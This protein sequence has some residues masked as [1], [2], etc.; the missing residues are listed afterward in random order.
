M[1][2]LIIIT[3]S[4]GT[5]STTQGGQ[6]TGMTNISA[7]SLFQVVGLVPLEDCNAEDCREQSPDVC[8][9]NPVFGNVIAG[10]PVDVPTYENDFNAFLVSFPANT[11]GVT[12]VVNF[13]LQKAKSPYLTMDEAWEWEDVAT[14]NDSTYGTYFPLF[15]IPSHNLYTGFDI[16]WGKVVFLLGS[17]VYRLKAN[18]IKTIR[19]VT[20]F[21]GVPVITISTTE[22]ACIVS[23][24]FNLYEWDCEKADGTVKFE[25]SLT[26]SIGS[27][28][29]YYKVFNLC[30]FQW[31]DSL[32]IRGF[33]GEET[34][35]KY[36]ELN[37]EYQSGRIELIHNKAEN[38]FKFHSYY[39]PKFIHDRLK[40]YMMMADTILV[41]DY[42]YNNSDY[43]VKRK[44][45]R[46]A[47]NYEPTYLDKK[48]FQPDMRYRQRTSEV[49]VDFRES[50]ESIIKSLCCPC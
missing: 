7:T 44:G 42:N 24:I 27:I 19:K 3:P 17:G 45:I 6:S 28:D 36:Q 16:N 49:K 25:T 2:E 50:V 32:R 26:G 10:V 37:L 4:G 9:M 12:P 29:E 30:G 48:F 46:P 43:N 5:A 47:G 11:S 23:K 34:T 18:I 20:F 39:L 35:P 31:Y 22:V 8:Y 33:F 13:I 41:S 14:C 1:P 38:R 21:N 15:S 40:A